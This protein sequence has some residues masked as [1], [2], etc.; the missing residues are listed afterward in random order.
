MPCDDNVITRDD[1]AILREAGEESVIPTRQKRS[2]IKEPESV[3]MNTYDSFPGESG[4]PHYE[5]IDYYDKPMISTCSKNCTRSHNVNPPG[6]T[7]CSRCLV[8][9][10]VFVLLMAMA[11]LA[12]SIFALLNTKRCSECPYYREGNVRFCWFYKR[13][14]YSEII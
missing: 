12:V 7:P 5:H 3:C 13:E 8:V 14:N 6:R 1:N 10:L 11:A 9:F 4:E 2:P